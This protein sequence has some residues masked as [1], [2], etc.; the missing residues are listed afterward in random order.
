MTPAAA[1]AQPPDLPKFVQ[2]FGQVLC[3][4]V[5]QTPSPQLP[6]VAGQSL[7]Q[8]ELVSPESHWPLPQVVVDLQSLG[9]LLGVSPDS[10]VPLPQT[11][12]DGGQS[13]GQLL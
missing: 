3:S 6:V 12:P 2:S 7:G 5:A 13:T 8:V 11:G 4:P 10:Q 9:Q 1:A